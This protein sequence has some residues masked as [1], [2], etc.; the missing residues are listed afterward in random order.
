[1]AS[2]RK[3]RQDPHDD[4][5]I[6][7]MALTSTKLPNDV[8]LQNTIKSV[9]RP[10]QQAEDHRFRYD[11]QAQPSLA[12]AAADSATDM[13]RSTRDQ[14]TPSYGVIPYLPRWKRSA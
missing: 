4:D 10:D 12:A 3:N 8:G 2:S 6:E 7:D 13:P 11:G 5:S 9:P 14:A 1:M